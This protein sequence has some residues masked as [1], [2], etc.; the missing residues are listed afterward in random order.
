[1]TEAP[2]QFSRDVK[3]LRLLHR[4]EHRGSQRGR[5]RRYSSR[6]GFI[7]W[8]G[9]QTYYHAAPRVPW[10]VR[11]GG[12]QLG[13]VLHESGW[14]EEWG[15]LI[16]ELSSPRF[17]RACEGIQI[18]SWG[19]RRFPS[20]C[21]LIESSMDNKQPLSSHN[22]IARLCLISYPVGAYR[23]GLRLS[24]TRALCCH[25]FSGCFSWRR[26]CIHGMF[27]CRH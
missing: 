14:I 16:P 15:G 10:T 27:R 12:E 22:S 4:G 5:G 17:L 19:S 25:V 8:R 7:Y 9:D 20:P 6:F 18:Y 23:I 2:A 24:S 3:A 11:G 26:Q 1:M 21:S 13:A